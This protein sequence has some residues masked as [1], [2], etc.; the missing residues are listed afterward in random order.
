MSGV[1]TL[2]EGD[3]DCGRPWPNGRAPGNAPATGWESGRASVMPTTSYSAAV[4]SSLFAT[5]ARRERNPLDLRAPSAQDDLDSDSVN[6]GDTRQLGA[7]R[8]RI[9]HIVLLD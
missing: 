7:S 3:F 1:L 5:V 8:R 4:R 2:I 9:H 6:F